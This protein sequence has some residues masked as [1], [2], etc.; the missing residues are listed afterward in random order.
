MR[1]GPA[2]VADSQGIPEVI[3][4]GSTLDAGFHH[5]CEALDLH[6]ER[7]QKLGIAFPPARHRLIVGA[8]V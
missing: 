1:P 5:A 2:Y 3:T 8:V 7:L 4:S 6:L